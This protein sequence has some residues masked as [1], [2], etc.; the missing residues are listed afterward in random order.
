MSHLSLEI[1]FPKNDPLT[2]L[3]PILSTVPH[4][5]FH[6]SRHLENAFVPIQNRKA[7]AVISFFSHATNCTNSI[8]VQLKI[9]ETWEEYVIFHEEVYE[10]LK[11]SFLTIITPNQMAAHS[12][13]DIHI[14]KHWDMLFVAK[15]SFEALHSKEIFEQVE[16]WGL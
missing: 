9:L 14:E 15:E 6:F 3:K 7:F 8:F 4:R 13:L 12:T 5:I 16:L 11:S 1:K 10:E 2:N